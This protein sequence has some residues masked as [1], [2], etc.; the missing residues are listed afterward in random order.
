MP[1]VHEQYL[2]SDFDFSEYLSRALNDIVSS[3]FHLSWTTFIVLMF[4]IVTWRLVVYVGGFTLMISFAVIPAVLLIA[5][6]F[7]V[8]KLIKV[9]YNLVP[10]VEYPTEF[11]IPVGHY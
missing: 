7:V 8:Q 5:L 6:F 3:I 10:Y 2:R 1:S 9:Y 4:F 11:V